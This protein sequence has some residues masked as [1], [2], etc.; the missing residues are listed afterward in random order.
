MSCRWP[1]SAACAVLL[2]ASASAA[3][4]DWQPV[5]CVPDESPTEAS[6]DIV[7]AVDDFETQPPKWD[8]LAAKEQA[9]V[10]L[11]CDTTEHHRGNVALRVDY[12]FAGYKQQPFNLNRTLDIPRP[13][14][15]FAFW[16]KTDGSALHFV[17]VTADS[18]NKRRNVLL[19]TIHRPGWQFMEASLD[20]PSKRW[21]D[22]TENPPPS[23]PCHAVGITVLSPH[24][25]FAGEGT[26]W[27]DDVALVRPRVPVAPSLAV[28][29]QGARL[30]NV[31]RVGE[32]VGLRARGKGD[33]IRWHWADFW[34]ETIAKGEGA[35]AQTTARFALKRLGYFDCALELM[36]GQQIKETQHFCAAVLPAGAESG[37]SDFLGMNTHFGFFDSDKRHT[38]LECMTLLR[39]YG[40]DQFRDGLGWESYER[41]PGRY[42]MRAEAIN[43]LAKA[44]QLK[45]RPLLNFAYGNPL[46]DNGGFPNS[47]GAI[48]AF[49]ASAADFARRTHGVASQFEVWNEWVGGC[50]MKDHP[51]VHDGAAYGRLLG[52]TYAAI[53][54]S[55]PQV[56][57]VG[58]GGEYGPKCCETIASAIKTAG[59]RSMDA[60]SIHPY[61]QPSRAPEEPAYRYPQRAPQDLDDLVSDVRRVA[62]VVAESGAT[63]KAWVTEIGWTLYHEFADPEGRAGI[64][65][66]AQALFAVRTLAL[67]ASTH[68]VEKVFWYDW[69]DDGLDREYNEDNFGVVH[70]QKYNCAPKPAAVAISVFLWLTR[71]APCGPLGHKGNAYAVCYKF[72]GDKQCLVVWA[73]K[74]NTPVRVSG[75]LATLYDLMGNTVEPSSP[76][77]LGPAPVYVTGANLRLETAAP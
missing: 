71:N 12:R 60:W 52:P 1:L 33:R 3:V 76:L 70:H 53:K 57:V 7:Q 32:T 18:A 17:L 5:A 43:F 23:Y 68:L 69:K 29:V 11:R 67:L 56:T 31:Y 4:H 37:R 62:Q 63:Q 42:Q 72:P 26:L 44:V 47:P 59:T 30:G 15:G 6:F 61:R 55:S 64:G 65:E 9:H 22:G 41:V 77:M 10:E 45:M 28:E 38:P 27:I 25:G 40:I 46:Y 49:A 58:I 73:T 14:L 2:A 20:G 19:S 75:D 50:G 51:G 8:A 48:A 16:L 66:Q 54:R 35:A 34:G 74:P 13:G 39:R 36:A 21:Q 24:P